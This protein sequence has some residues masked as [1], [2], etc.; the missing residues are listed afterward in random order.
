M[1]KRLIAF[2]LC[3]VLLVA[4]ALPAQAGVA[5]LDKALSRWLAD[6]TSVR[7]SATMKLNSLMPFGD[8]TLAMLNGVLKHITINATIA[9]NGDDNSTALDIAMDGNS[10][11]SLAETLQSGAYTL[12][13]S[14][15]PNRTLTSA[16]QSPM[17]MLTA[18]VT[19]AISDAPATPTVS[20]GAEATAAP[21]QTDA[22][23]NTSDIAGAFSL[24]DA[25]TELQANY[26]ALT[27]GITSFATEK[28]SNYNIKGIGAGKWSR[29]ARLTPEQS[30]GLLEQLRAV[31]SSGMDDAYRAEL[32][33]ATFQ[34]GFIVA[35][36]QNADKQDICVYLKGNL[37]YPDKTQR[38]LV[39]QW[40]FT[41]NGL[42][43][44]DMFKYSVSKLG[45][46]ADTRTVEASC[47][48]ES[49]SDLFKILGRSET[50]LKRAKLTDKETARTDLSGKK[51]EAGALTC[52]GDVS[53][54]LV[55]TDGTDTEKNNTKTSVDLL[56]TPDTEGSVLSGTIHYQTLANKLPQTDMEIMLATDATAA[57]GGNTQASPETTAADS[58]APSNSATPTVDAQANGGEPVSSIEQIGGDF[59]EEPAATAAPDGSTDYLV[60]SAPVG[61]Q[62]FTTPQTMVS[63]DLD[64]ADA[65]KVES[66]LTEAA[67]NFAGK[68]LVAMAALPQE[69]AALLRDGMSEQDFA[70]FLTLLQSL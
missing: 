40:A 28:S 30:A 34:K 59:A 7:F 35:L 32:A 8:D 45:G 44:T 68:L 61:M 38:K 31:L 39:W 5:S 19:P 18:P 62:V 2:S 65:D 33:Q 49:R 70:A 42:K 63:V 60:G 22:A 24:L 57:T 52:T 66:L 56:F 21:K 41:T 51:T 46:A 25:I 55:Q 64:Q 3:L 43:R 48:Q 10:L 14:L 53:Q 4:C 6:Q 12:E 47:T 58:A 50:T 16:K 54:E 27:D 13:T 15:L 20:D 9:Q 67:Q 26:Q 11:M 29:I 17:D 69:D 1:K 37:D 36:Y 23:A